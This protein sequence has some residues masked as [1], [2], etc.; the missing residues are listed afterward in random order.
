MLGRKLCDC[1][2]YYSPDLEACPKCKAPEW[3]AS[4]IPYNPLDWVYDLETY[5]NIFTADF[6]H[7]A[8]GTRLLFE[9]SDR[10]NQINELF[11]FLM[12][13]KGAG[14]RMVGFNNNGFDYPIIHFIIVNYWSGLT[15]TDIFNKAQAIIDTPWSNRFDNVIWDNDVH[16]V[17][18]DLYKIHHFD[19]DARRTSLKLLEFN[20]GMD[21]IE[22]LPYPPGTLLNGTQKDVLIGYNDH[23]VDAT[24]LFLFESIELIEF[25]EELSEKYGRNFLNHNDTKIG[26][27]Y[28]IMRLEESIPGSC[29]ARNE[30][31]K[32][33]PRQTIREAIPLADVIF[34]Y[35]NFKV[36][37]FER[38]KNWLAAQVLTEKTISNEI[39]LK[40]VFKD[41]NAT[42]NGFTYDFGS[43]G[44]HGSIPSG[45]VY[46][47]DDYVI[48]DW[49]VASYYP[50]LAIANGLYPEHLSS[51]FCTIYKDVFEQR[52]Q[53]KKGTPENAMLKL[54]LNGVYGDSNSKYSP[55]YDPQY[56]MSITINGQLL[57]C[58]LAQYLIDVPD[59]EMIQVNTD[60]LTIRYPRIHKQAV[61][62]ICKW[63]E[64]YTQLELESA[65]YSRMFIRDVNNYIAEYVNE[66]GKVKRKGAYEYNLEWHQDFS[67]LV[68]PMA[69]EAALLHGQCI[70]DFICNHT[71]INDFMLRT[72]VGR[73]DKLMYCESIELQRITRYYI[74]NQ[75]GPLV[76][77]SPP[78]KGA[79]VG[80]WKRASKLTD[81]F[82]NAVREELQASDYPMMDPSTGES[83]IDADGLP[84]D[85]RINTKNRSVYG[86]RRTSINAGYLVAPCNNI[87]DAIRD[88]INYDYYI[89]EAEK[90]VKPLRG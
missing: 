47:D 65:I 11:E 20:M 9:I 27:D 18:I 50:N 10:V 66:T 25:R 55:F 13:L 2:E 87:K 22:D 59:L 5:P 88:N 60:G 56:T 41:V 30:F 49:D 39:N 43:G 44:I 29:Y 3:S 46:S 51:E 36:A 37:E 58:M 54:A 79:T 8:T 78:A 53:Y 63:W 61:H 90:L 74:A 42:I 34:P 35:I 23:D 6:K 72:K 80:A 21:T 19:N 76:K 68:V 32:R 83:L 69:A 4:F 64:G 52:R 16:I 7:P 70:D 89:A 31:N 86:I 85:E 62:D 73:A 1:G 24:E 14:C 84:W 28:F 26:K 40:G 82:Y 48:E 81:A 38:V 12:S 17:Q 71:D 33:V 75:G 15:V 67:A 57:L 77:I 45:I